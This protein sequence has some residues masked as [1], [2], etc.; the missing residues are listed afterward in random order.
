M[1]KRVNSKET[2]GNQIET[3]GAAAWAESSK[4]PAGF[5]QTLAIGD[6]EYGFCWIPAGEFDMGSPESE[7][8]RDSDEAL[9]H[10]ELTRGFWAF[11]TL[12]PQA[13]YEEIMGNNPS[14][15]RKD[16]FP[17]ET[18][19]WDDAT[20]FCKALAKRLPKGVKA[21]L[22]TEAQWEYACRAGT[23]TAFWYGDSSDSDKMNYG[24]YR[25]AEDMSPNSVKEYP[26]NP[27]G[28]YDMH[29]NLWEWVLD[30]YGDYPKGPV[31]DPKG[32]D[33]GSV[34]VC[35]GGSWNNRGGACRSASRDWHAPNGKNQI[36]GFRFLLSCE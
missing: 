3:G 15:N 6:V 8:M 14:E 24:K 35:R 2:N 30:W 1:T 36:I 16:D 11:E 34:R 33:V 20:S 25:Y 17:V 18:T 12:T 29:G 5:R 27:W 28:L 4:R 10:V 13:L 31:V 23:R 21:T 7:E 32:P 22:P 19:T 26:A 9:C